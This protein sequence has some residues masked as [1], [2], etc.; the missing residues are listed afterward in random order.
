[1]AGEEAPKKQ[2]SAKKEEVKQE[3]KAVEKKDED[4]K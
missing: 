2:V 3:K 1:M 4:I